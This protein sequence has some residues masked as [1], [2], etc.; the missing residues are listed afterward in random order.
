MKGIIKDA[1]FLFIITLIAG[2]CL[3]AVHEITLEPIAQAQLAANTATYQEVYPD[4]ASFDTNEELTQAIGTSAE[5]IA[6]Q[7]YGSVTVDSVQEALDASG[8]VIGNPDRN[9]LSEYFRDC[10]T[11]NECPE[12]GV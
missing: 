5:E 9:R 7:G 10:R 12:S 4:A 6:A 1:V 2:V 8:N 3:G 11:G